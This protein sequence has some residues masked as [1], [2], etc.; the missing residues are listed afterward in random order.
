[1]HLTGAAE[2]QVC[3]AIDDGVAVWIKSASF[4]CDGIAINFYVLSGRVLRFE[5]D[6][7][8]SEKRL[9]EIDGL[10]LRDFMI[11]HHLL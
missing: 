9:D 2:R 11:Y 7:D 10:D 3:A 8:Y 5:Y 6:Q 1:M 4:T